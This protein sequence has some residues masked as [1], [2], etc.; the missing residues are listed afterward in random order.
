MNTSTVRLYSLGFTNVKTYLIASLFVIGN[1]LFP[2]LCHIMPKGGLMLLPIYFFTLIGAY[3]YGMKTG[4]LI[5]VL[6]PV[7]NYALV[8]MPPISILPFILIKS[9]LLAVA[10]AI[11]AQKTGKISLPAIL[12]VVLAYQIIGSPVEYFFASNPTL[13]VQDFVIGYPGLIFQ[14]IGGYFMLKA[15]ARV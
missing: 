1:I 14:A 12:V 5:A 13:A 2:Q 3:K 6:S 7:L 11:A 10:A 8:G 4:L 9:C 15:L